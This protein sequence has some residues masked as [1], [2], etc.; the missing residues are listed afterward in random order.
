VNLDGANN[1]ATNFATRLPRHLAFV[2]DDGGYLLRQYSQGANIGFQWYT[3]ADFSGN[4]PVVVTGNTITNNRT[5]VLVQSQGL[6]DSQL[7]SDC[8]QHFDGPE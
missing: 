6:A 7:Q 4:N 8:R 3:P 1:P 2:G 5:G